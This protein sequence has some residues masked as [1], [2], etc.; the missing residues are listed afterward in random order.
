MGNIKGYFENIEGSAEDL[1]TTS[2][3]Q[4]VAKSYKNLT[5]LGSW[6][7]SDGFDNLFENLCTKVGLKVEP[8]PYGVRRRETNK[9]DFW[10][11]YNSHDVETK[12]GI[13]KAADFLKIKRA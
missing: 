10:F 11:N 1:L 4:S 12:F 8:M 2:D 9:F 3:K 13:I 7:D 6:L 5:Y